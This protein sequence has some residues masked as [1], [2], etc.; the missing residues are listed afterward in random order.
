MTALIIGSCS[1]ATTAAPLVDAK[2]APATG[3]YFGVNLDFGNDSAAA[4][5][6]RIGHQAAV[7]VQFVQFPL[8]A[9]AIATLDAFVDQVKS[10]NG[11]GMITLE[12]NAGLNAVTVANAADFADRVAAYNKRGVPLFIRF[13]HEMNGS[14]YPWGQSPTLYVSAFRLLA[15]AIHAR[16]PQTAM[17]W[18]PNYGGGYPFAGG[19]YEAKPGTPDFALLDTNH[20]GQLTMGDDPYQPYYPGDDAVDWVGM[21]VYHWGDQYPWGE[22]EIPEPHKFIDIITGTYDGQNGDERAVPDF[23]AVYAVSHHKPMAIT[24]TAALY[25]TTTTGDAELALKQAWWRQVFAPE[26]PRDFPQIKMINWFEWRK[27]ESEVGGAVV[28]WRATS[29]AAV[30]KAFTSDLPGWLLFAH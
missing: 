25:N 6:Q 16:A 12:P 19:T 23:Y 1:S 17:V 7:Y 20:D 5:N 9:G 24:E 27:S 3:V 11:M 28:D 8:D 26:I 30:T 21:S 10:Q 15:S 4:F 22:N 2:Q 14:W 29:N 13:A 18:A